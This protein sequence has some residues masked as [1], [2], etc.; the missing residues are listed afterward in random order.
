MRACVS[1]TKD[2]LPGEANFSSGTVVR[3]PLYRRD[4]QSR[5]KS[6]LREAEIFAQLFQPVSA[7]QSER[8][9]YLCLFA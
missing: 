5:K 7:H 1:P 4:P 3:T 6:P 9:N 2:D 8:P